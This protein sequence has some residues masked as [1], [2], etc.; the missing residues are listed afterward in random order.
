MTQVVNLFAGPGAGKSTTAS[1]LFASLKYAGVNCELAS[2]YAKDLV[3]GGSQHILANQIY[4]F[5][6]QYHRIWRLLDKVDVIITDSPLLMSVMYYNG[7][8]RLFPDMVWHEHNK[9]NNFNVLVE[10]VKPYNP[11]GRL[12][13][14]DEAKKLDDRIAG[15]IRHAGPYHKVLGDE[16]ASLKIVEK[17][18]LEGRL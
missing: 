3:W 10:R 4:V 11:A 7:D 16:T 8:N 6:K 14:E 1:A 18:V 15:I 5:G 13:T 12:Q 9:L 2:E 17:M